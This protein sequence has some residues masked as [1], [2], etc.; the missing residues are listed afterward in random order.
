MLR[1]DPAK[2]NLCIKKPSAKG[3]QQLFDNFSSY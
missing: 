3:Y 2:K 1:S